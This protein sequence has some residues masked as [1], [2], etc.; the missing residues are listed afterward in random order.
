MS[1]ALHEMLSALYGVTSH[2]V[3][4]PLVDEIDIAVT[5]FLP[6]NP[7]RL[8]FTFVNL[9]VN[10]IYIAPS[11]QVAATFGIRLAPNGGMIVVQWDRDFEMV[12]QEWWATAAANNS[13]V[14]CL[15]NIA[16]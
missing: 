2:I 9:S 16:D 15:E 11:N 8:S 10:I 6:I 7:K 3:N 1:I 12:S 4:N 13:A 14:Y 5:R